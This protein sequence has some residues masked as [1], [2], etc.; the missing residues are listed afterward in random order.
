MGKFKTDFHFLCM[1]CRDKNNKASVVKVKQQDF[2]KICKF[3]K[4]NRTTI[5]VKANHYKRKN[6]MCTDSKGGHT[7]LC[8]IIGAKDE[9][10]YRALING[11]DDDSSSGSHTSSCS[12][13]E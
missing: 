6:V 3:T 13:S 1:S 2:L 5:M 11:C 9:K 4:G 10:R 7:T 8:K 12:S